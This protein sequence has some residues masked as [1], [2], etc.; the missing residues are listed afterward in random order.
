MT[1]RPQRSAS[2]PSPSSR[3][4]SR[5]G[6]ESTLPR[7][8]DHG[9]LFDL[10]YAVRLADRTSSLADNSRLRYEVWATS[11]APADLGRK[12]ADLGVQTL[13]D[14]SISGY[15]GQLGRRAPALGLRLYLMAGSAALALAIGRCC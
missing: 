14:E 7:I 3:S 9:L 8:G 15:L 1:R 12:L 11:S 4:S 10:D 13:G 6:Q 2:Q 5:G